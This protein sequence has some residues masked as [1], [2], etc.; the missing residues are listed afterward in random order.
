MSEN[1]F[2]LRLSFRFSDVDKLPAGDKV[3]STR[4]QFGLQNSAASGYRTRY[5][6]FGFVKRI[7]V[8]IPVELQGPLCILILSTQITE[9]DFQGGAYFP[10]ET[11]CI[12][13]VKLIL[14][15]GEY[16]FSRTI[17]Q[18]KKESQ[19]SQYNDNFNKNLIRL[20]SCQKLNNEHSGSYFFFFLVRE[21]ALS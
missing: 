20:R 10:D 8:E 16:L 13:Q 12:K 17:Q 11:V 4:P 19:L 2:L 7:L 9:I 18:K 3:Q 15:R 14:K 6:D 1:C 5:L 21:L